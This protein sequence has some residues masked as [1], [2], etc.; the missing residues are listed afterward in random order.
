MSTVLGREINIIGSSLNTYGNTG[1]FETDRSTWGFNDQATYWT[2]TRSGLYKLNGSWAAKCAVTGTKTPTKTTL[3]PGNFNAI[4]GKKYLI[5][6]SCYIPTG[7]TPYDLVGTLRLFYDTGWTFVIQSTKSLSSAVGTWQTV[8]L[9]IERTGANLNNAKVYIGVDDVTQTD[10]AAGDIYIDLFWIRE[11]EDIIA[12]CTLAIDSVGTTVTDESSPAANDGT[13]DVATTGGTAPLEYS[14]DNINWQSSTQFTGLAPGV[15]TIYVRD[16]ASTP[17][18]ASEIFSVNAASIAFDFTVSVTDESVTGYGDGQIEITVSGT[19]GPFTYSKDGGSNYQASNI[20]SNLSPGNYPIVVKDAADN[21]KSQIVSVST[22]IVVFDSVYFSKNHIPYLRYASLNYAENNYKVMIDVQVEDVA[23]SGTFISKMKSAMPPAIS[24]QNQQIQFNLRPA[25]R[26][27]LSAN[28][29][30][31]GEN[32]IIKLTDRI[33]LYKI[34]YGDIYDQMEEPAVWTSSS[35]YL[36]LFGGISKFKF[37]TINYFYSFLPD[38]KKFMTW[39]PV[40]KD[41]DANQEDYLQFWVY[42]INYTSVKQMVKAYF[43]D[44]TTETNTI[45]SKTVAYGDLLQLP[46]GPVNC[47]AVGINPAKNMTKYDVW[48]T[49]QDDTVITEVRTYKLTPFKHPRT[50]YYLFLNSLGAYEV[51]RTTGF[52]EE[53]TE[54][55]RDVSE[56]LLPIGYEPLDGQYQA[57][58][59][60]KRNSEKVSSGF[61]AGSNSK[62]WLKHM[63]EVFLSSKIY[64]VTGG[65]RV[66][67]INTTKSLVVR[68][69]EDNKRFV[70]FEFVQA[71]ADHSYTPD[72]I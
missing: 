15:Y 8:Q 1:N 6:C 68:K 22:G 47:G 26:G 36:V 14:K 67:V 19:G 11:Y 57:G 27:V 12:P 71:Y 4:Q 50:K 56:K 3:I 2:A 54:I 60:I 24:A 29:P 23:D 70:R 25:F 33:K 55:D 65:T 17:C 41:I 10:G 40:V 21:T 35:T 48:L 44:D 32:S 31:Q 9:M 59:A 16:S 30:N 5:E 37:P 18:T 66:P 58:D 52:S 34:R 20:F 72:D 62:E 39:A 43:D 49:N 7:G 53:S 51:L 38:N 42:N 46:A 64:D 61:F 45:S 63:Q 69:N 13:I 28:P